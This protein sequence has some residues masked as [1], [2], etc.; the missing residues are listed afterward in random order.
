[1][2]NDKRNIAKFGA[3]IQRVQAEI[4]YNTIYP[5]PNND[6]GTFHNFCRY[7]MHTNIFTAVDGGT[8]YHVRHNVDCGYRA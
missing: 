6:C 8:S 7:Y 1:M 5:P 4:P 3:K 2:V